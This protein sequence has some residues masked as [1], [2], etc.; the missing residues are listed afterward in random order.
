MS[1][2]DHEKR[3]LQ[4]MEAALLTEDPRLFSALSGEARPIR[5][6]SV[7]LGLGLMLLGVAVLFGGLIAKITPVGVL[8]FIIALAGVIALLSSLSSISQRTPGAK[9]ARRKNAL[10]SRLEQRW[11]ERNNQ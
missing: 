2:S 10:G 4:E 8:G 9:G 1:L 11:E 3:M 7:L 6:N 5:R